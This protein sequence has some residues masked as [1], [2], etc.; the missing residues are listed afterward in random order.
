MSGVVTLKLLAAPKPTLPITL[1]CTVITPSRDGHASQLARQRR[2]MM[3]G[4]EMQWPAAVAAAQAAA[5]AA[6]V[7]SAAGVAGGKAER[8][9][10][11]WE[12]DSSEI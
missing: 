8:K 2:R 7:Q 10:P 11:G 1:G 4:D 6:S 9:E 5:G 12:T 3:C